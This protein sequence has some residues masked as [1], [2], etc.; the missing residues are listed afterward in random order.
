MS[1]I[2]AGRP[3]RGV[4]CGFLRVF[5]LGRV[6]AGLPVSALACVWR[7]ALQRGAQVER[8]TRGT[9]RKFFSR[10][11]RAE[12]VRL[13]ARDASLVLPTRRSGRDGQRVSARRDRRMTCRSLISP[14]TKAVLVALFIFA[15]LLIL[16][17]ILWYICRDVD[18]DHGI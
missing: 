3:A 17:V 4:S 1:L 12:S 6:L 7:L 2:A 13:D 8:K 15:I 16:Y 11:L 18:C 10:L 14:V 5:K 9:E